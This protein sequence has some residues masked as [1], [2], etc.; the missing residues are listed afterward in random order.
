MSIKF[1][2]YGRQLPPRIPRVCLLKAHLAVIGHGSAYIPMGGQEYQYAVN[3]VHLLLHPTAK[4]TWKVWGTTVMDI[5]DFIETY[6]YVDLDFDVY[7]E[8][9]QGLNTYVGTGI[10]TAF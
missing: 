3:D 8:S 4:M 5:L 10:L 2:G 1:Y 6:A 7:E 9:D